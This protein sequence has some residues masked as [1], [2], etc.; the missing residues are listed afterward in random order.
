M[1]GISVTGSTVYDLASIC[2]LASA[3]VKDDAKL[4]DQ[5]AARAVE[6][7]RQAFAKGY[8]EAAHMKKDK[9]LDALR[10][11]EDFKRLVAELETKKE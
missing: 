2:A 11:R 6:L 1:P 7:L 8:K 3:A 4:Q 10:D 5:Y 9:D